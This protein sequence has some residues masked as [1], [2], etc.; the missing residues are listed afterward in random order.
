MKKYR[1]KK[2]YKGC[3]ICS[4]LIIM[5]KYLIS[6]ICSFTD[7]QFCRYAVLQICILQICRFVDLSIFGVSVF[8]DKCFYMYMV[9]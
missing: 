6:Q 8:L 1:L 7:M 5:V 9:L 3:L 4:S 2:K